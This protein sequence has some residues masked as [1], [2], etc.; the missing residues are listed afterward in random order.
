[1]ARLNEVE[2]LD[3]QQPP[4]RDEA[5]EDQ[6]IADA[7]GFRRVARRLYISHSLSTW[8]S[9]MF[10]FGAFLFLA[11]VF[12][13]TLLFASVYALAR[14]L[15]VFLL[16]SSIGGIMDVSNRLWAIRASISEQGLSIVVS[17]G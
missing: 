12:P 15:T 9:R 13:E 14:S 6:S 1:M 3:T 7:E 17:R 16:S 4:L 5:A 10:E 11:D 2:S 8:N